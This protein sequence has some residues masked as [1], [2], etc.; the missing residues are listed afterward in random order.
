MEEDWQIG[1]SSKASSASSEKSEQI[2]ILNDKLLSESL[3]RRETGDLYK[4]LQEE[5]DVLLAKH[6]QAENTI[7]QLRIGAR[8]DLFSDGPS[9]KQAVESKIIEFKLAPQPI[10]HSTKSKRASI[11]GSHQHEV[12]TNAPV[13]SELKEGARI[14]HI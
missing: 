10:S 4:R 5:Y 13:T 7:D 8:V 3:S 9:Q 12:L 11:S 14:Y 2:R 1:L 6:A